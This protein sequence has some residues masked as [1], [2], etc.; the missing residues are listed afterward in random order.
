MKGSFV[1]RGK[2]LVSDHP[3][4]CTM[5][6]IELLLWHTRHRAYL[7][8]SDKDSRFLDHFECRMYKLN[9]EGKDVDNGYDFVK[10]LKWRGPI[11]KGNDGLVLVVCPVLVRCQ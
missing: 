10:C 2:P 6:C 8:V 7:S 11:L 9:E 4:S 1:E 3:C 5:L